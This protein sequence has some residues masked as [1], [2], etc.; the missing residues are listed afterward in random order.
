MMPL[1]GTRP[2]LDYL[3]SSLADAGLHEVCLVVG[4]EHDLVR[5]RYLNDETLNRVSVTM[6]VQPAPTGTADALLAAETWVGDE[7]FIVLNGDNYYP[8]DGLRLLRNAGGPATLAFD[9]KALIEQSNIPAARIARYALLEA[10]ANGVLLDVIE[11]PD[12]ATMARLASAAVSMNV[13]RFD[14]EI[15]HACRDVPPSPR[16]ELELP[17]AVRYAVQILGLRIE[18]IPFAGGV[19]DLSSRADVASVAARLRDVAVRL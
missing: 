10:N 13:W 3:L 1:D 2:L 11:K 18:A 5:S 7:Q 4:P 15:F 19:L 12:D 17:L 14:R 6:A 9:R 8:P 16:G